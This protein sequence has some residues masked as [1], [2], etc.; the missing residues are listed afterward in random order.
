MYKWLEAWRA[1]KAGDRERCKKILKEV[2]AGYTSCTDMP[3]CAML[4]ELVEIYPNAK[5]IIV[6]RDPDRWWASMEEH[7]TKVL[8]WWGPFLMPLAA[9]GRWFPDFAN[10]WL[11]DVDE[12]VG[13]RDKWG[14]QI[15]IKHNEMCRT[16]VPKDRQL[17]YSL[18]QGWEPLAKFLGVPVPENEPFPKV[19]EAAEGTK[20]ATRMLG[21]VLVRWACLLSA[22]GGGL[23]AG[24][25]YY[26]EVY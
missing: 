6:T 17:E 21:E 19:N 18:D 25:R 8:P 14:P 26:S 9:R 13:G 23:Y 2:T 1:K 4:P 5:V 11:E 12:L 15:M 24:L 10:I 3:P 16:L 7:L 22:V 20:V